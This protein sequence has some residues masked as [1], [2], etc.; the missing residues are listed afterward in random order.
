L[1]S[2]AASSGHRRLGVLLLL[3]VLAAGCVAGY[4]LLRDASGFDTLRAHREALLVWR[5]GHYFAAVI[6]YTAAFVGA[7]AFSLP[8]SFVLTVTGGFL[9]GILPGTLLAVIAGTAG[10]TL[11]FL[12]VRAG[13]AEPL[14][15]RLLD[16]GTEGRFARVERGLK[17]NEVSYLL[18]LR[19]V[20]IVP[21][22]IANLAPAFLGVSAGRFVA[23]TF[24]GIAPGTALSAWIGVGIGEV[25]D[26]G[27]VPD[28]ALLG[29]P[30][31]LGPFLALIALVTLPIVLG[32]LRSRR[33]ARRQSAPVVRAAPTA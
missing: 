2:P 29:E 10:A 17:A 1:R 9:F 12:A 6:I 22:P 11:V 8:G 3:A 19:L 27:D 32:R 26:R 28:L 13:L 25:F 33:R 18:L 24:I 23:T 20:P 16:A 4:F 30:R 14:R 7:V 15:R 21:F 5:D 31:I